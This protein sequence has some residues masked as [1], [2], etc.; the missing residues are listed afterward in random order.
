MHDH[1]LDDLI[2]DNIEPKNSKTKS[3]LT[4]IALLIVVLIVAI[5]LTKI[6]LKTPDQNRLAFEEDTTELIAPELQLKETPKSEKVKEE[7]SLSNV[8]ESKP[9]AP[10]VETKKES[11]K[12][13]TV[14]V[15]KETL[16][17]DIEDQEIKA[18]ASQTSKENMVQESSL[19]LKEKE[20]KDAADIAYWKKMQEKRKAEQIAY[21]AKTIEKPTVTVKEE[22][23]VKPK[24]I[25]TPTPVVTSVKKPVKRPVASKSVPK[26]VSTGRYYVQ[27]GAYRQQPSKRFI[28]VIQNNGYKY[29]MTK[30]SRSGIKRLLIGPYSD[31]ESVDRVLIDVR[32]RI[33]KHAFITTR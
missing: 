3:L 20:A 16:L 7:P 29:I 18:P 31:R 24:T 25:K 11:I 23:T 22:K 21:E 14:V 1:N 8:I 26:M 30:P 6:L 32:D 5:I 10:V 9:Q 27:V 4:I 15:Q 12:Q 19:A 33:H 17:S 13:S 2:I 28:S